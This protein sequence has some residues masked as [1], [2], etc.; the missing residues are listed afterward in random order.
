MYDQNTIYSNNIKVIHHIQN[1]IMN[2][3]Y[4]SGGSFAYTTN[5]LDILYSHKRFN[6]NWQ[7]PYAGQDE[8]VAKCSLCQL[9]EQ[10]QDVGR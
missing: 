4:M 10:T 1:N 9:F 5:V 7:Y 2:P 6:Q 3:L 8:L